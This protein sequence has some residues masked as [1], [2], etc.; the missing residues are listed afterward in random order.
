MTT[1]ELTS[2][3]HPATARSHVAGNGAEPHWA[4]QAVLSGA[5]L[6][7]EGIQ[8]SRVAANSLI[9]VADAMLLGTFDLIEEW[10]SALAEQ[11]VPAMT[12]KPTELARKVYTT[13]S[14]ALRESISD[15]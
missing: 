6:V 15:F 9:D 12:A 2:E 14:T 3:T 4:D 7:N 13:A 10:N 1:A 5:G 8:R 11:I